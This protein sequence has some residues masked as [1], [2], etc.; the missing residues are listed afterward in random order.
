MNFNENVPLSLGVSP[1]R[2]KVIQERVTSIAQSQHSDEER[3]ERLRYDFPRYEEIIYAAY[4]LNPI[5]EGLAVKMVET[6]VEDE[7]EVSEG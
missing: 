5:K 7:T 2:A 4:L 3:L 6:D 1:E